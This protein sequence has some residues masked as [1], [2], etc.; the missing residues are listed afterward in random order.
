[1]GQAIKIMLR[2]F[3]LKNQAITGELPAKI[4]AR[5]LFAA[6]RQGPLAPNALF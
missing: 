4:I 6:P 5:Q 2:K 3:H 1:M